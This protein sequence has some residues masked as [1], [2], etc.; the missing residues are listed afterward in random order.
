MG[1]AQMPHLPVVVSHFEH[2]VAYALDT[3]QWPP[4]Q[5][6]LVQW[7]GAEQIAPAAF[8]EHLESAMA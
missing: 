8:D 4:I 6:V 5:V 1:A 3:Q 7:A 2:P